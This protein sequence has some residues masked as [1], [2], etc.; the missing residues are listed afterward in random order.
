MAQQAGLALVAGRARRDEARLSLLDDRGRIARDMHDHVIQRLFATGLSLQSATAVVDD[1]IVRARLDS[2]VDEL[3]A[4]IK[5]IRHTIFQLHDPRAQQLSDDLRHLVQV[6][7]HGAG[8][9]PVLTLDPTLATLS[10]PLVDDLVAVVREGLSNAVRH[11]RASTVTVDVRQQEGQVVVRVEDDGVGLDP[12]QVRSGL[13]NLGDRATRRDGAFV[14]ERR[15][16]RG[17]TLQWRAPLR[18]A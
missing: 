2:A 13:V 12:G 18:G 15:D 10:T 17:T 5:E 6:L 16:P 4:A 7:S 3:D 14:V 11:A 9:T 1:P 8:P